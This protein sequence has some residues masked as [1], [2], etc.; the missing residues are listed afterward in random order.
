MLIQ[1]N[2]DNHVQGSQALID[3]VQ[4]EVGATLERFADRIT[5]VEVHLG[6]DNGPKHGA[7]DKRC[8]I[9]ARPAGHSPI[10]ASHQSSDLDE[11][12]TGAIEKLERVLDRSFD[13]RDETKGRTSF[14]GDQ[15]I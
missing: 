7:G 6:D 1:V 4:A 13:K 9:E 14:G 2:T 12:I 8:S 5:R 10:S 11:A 3:R 15:Q